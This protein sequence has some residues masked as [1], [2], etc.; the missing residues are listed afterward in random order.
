MI[1]P[2]IDLISDRA[3]QLIG[4]ETLALDAGSPDPLLE[5][6]SRVGEVAV[7][8]ID[9][10]RG[11]GN[12]TSRIQQLCRQGRCRV[13]GGI[14]TVEQAR[15][16]L[17]AGAEKIIVG[18]AASPEL[19]SQL[20]KDRVIAALD[21]KDGDVVIEGWRKSTGASVASRMQELRDFVGGFLVTF[22]EKEGR[23]EGTRL[24]LAAD[25]VAAA[26]NARVTIAGGVT[27]AD[28]IASLDAIGADAQVGMALYRGELGLAEAV[29][30]PL[31]SDRPDGLWPTLVCDEAGRGLGLAYSN[32]ES[33][34]VALETGSGVYWSRTRGLW[35]KGA[36]SG[37]T[38]QL[39][40]VDV[41]CDRDTLRFV[42]RVAGDGF[43]HLG[44]SDCFGSARGLSALESTLR[45]RKR[46][47][48]ANS[49]AKR[50]FDD[51]S[52]LGGKLREEAGE[53]ANVQLP[54][55]VIHE[56]ADVLFFVAAKLAATGQS[57]AD[58]ERE[59]D[60]RALR[61]SRRPGDAKAPPAPIAA[62]RPESEAGS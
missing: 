32:L 37:A 11:N 47:A 62:T 5:R 45:R 12:N 23:M 43:C 20:P 16:W 28:D 48:P 49:Y 7:I 42:V 13:G 40:R 50:L 30:A 4:G 57:F 1:I 31:K 3:V 19:L 2:S 55:E 21:A 46:N 35:K 24:D 9:A 22:V 17:D 51:A 44:T 26:K 41:D 38:Q 14:R 54:Q 59:L 53:L 18:T 8:D 27:T 33:L 10:A 29:A 58:V 56:A 25:L 34:S 61:V 52:L 39:L 36:T 6:F 15:A 60:R